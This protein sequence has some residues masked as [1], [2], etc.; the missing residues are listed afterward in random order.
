MRSAGRPTGAFETAA[1]SDTWRNGVIQGF[2]DMAKDALI[3]GAAGAATA[4]LMHVG[5]AAL[6]GQ[7]FGGK[8][9]TGGAVEVPPA[10]AIDPARAERAAADLLRSGQAPWAHYANLAAQMGEHETVVHDRDHERPPQAR[11]RGVHRG[12]GGPRP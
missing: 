8:P 1:K 6:K 4:G 3:G 2:G 5:I 9:G 7:L 11:R 12:G 10:S